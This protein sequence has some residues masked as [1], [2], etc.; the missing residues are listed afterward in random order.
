MSVAP[1]EAAPEAGQV[2]AGPLALLLGVVAAATVGLGGTPSW[3]RLAI[4]I[5]LALAFGRVLVAQAR[6]GA[7]LRWWALAL[8]GL[9]PVAA[10][11][12]LPTLRADGFLFAAS[13][14]AA[15]TVAAA[16]VAASTRRADLVLAVLACLSTA[17]ALYGLAAASGLLPSLGPDPEIPVDLASGTFVN[18]NHFAGAVSIGAL[19]LTGVLLTP[20]GG[21]PGESRAGARP[22][23]RLGAGAMLAVCVAALYRSDSKGG[24]LAFASAAILTAS[25]VLLRRLRRNR[26]RPGALVLGIS[27]PAALAA[28]AALVVRSGLL[29]LKD[30]LTIYRDTLALVADHPLAGVGPGM[31]R[32]RFREFQTP[33]LKNTYYHAHNDYLELAAEWGLPVAAMLLALLGWW[34]AVQIRTAVAGEDDSRARRSLL[35]LAPVVGLLVHGLVDFN[36]QIPANALAFAALLGCGLGIQAPHGGRGRAG[37]ALP[38]AGLVSLIA[39]GI[40][41]VSG[42]IAGH[43]L[44][45]RA[46]TFGEPSPVNLER[47]ARLDPRNA[48]TLFRLGF[49]RRAHGDNPG[50]LEALER[51]VALQPADWRYWQEAATSYELAQRRPEAA[52]ALAGA[53]ERNPRDPNL[54]WIHANFLLRGG[55]LEGGLAAFG[56]ALDAG[57]NGRLGFSVFARAGASF[58]QLRAVWPGDARSQ[59][60]LLRLAARRDSPL[61]PEPDGKALLE[62]WQAS[63]P[64]PDGRRDRILRIF[65]EQGLTTE[66]R[67]GWADWQ[68]FRGVTDRDYL[69][70]HNLLWNGDFDAAFAGTDFGWKTAR[71]AA[72]DLALRSLD[73][74]SVL[75]VRPSPGTLITQTAVLDRSGTYELSVR[76]RAPHCAPALQWMLVQRGTRARAFLA[77]APTTA[78]PEIRV[79]EIALE[80][81][82]TVN[83]TLRGTSS[84]SCDQVIL[85]AVRLIRRPS[86]DAP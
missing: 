17:Q 40:L 39:I 42:L 41:A 7:S 4:W 51:A 9:A 72:E 81:P 79:T 57:T 68:A 3:I 14:W 36:L 61:R 5:P 83:V 33:N 74:E 73:G 80:G 22:G 54:A 49:V 64:A 78:K 30:R 66:A 10:F 31:Y 85:E 2:P 60:E 53:R 13:V 48:E 67:Q 23:L 38:A 34:L 25:L 24:W 27:V 71:K 65:A 35:L 32:W 75:A 76:Y 11:V 44:A 69:D 45:A 84:A 12:G 21:Q 29:S 70:G 77:L 26:N 63:L 62:V 20:F 52:E 8:P 19:I 43:R 37:N 82:G 50:A 15:L 47:A 1:A 46:L 55:D 58:D 18:P 59:L 86:G 56:R 16:A 6:R 28:A